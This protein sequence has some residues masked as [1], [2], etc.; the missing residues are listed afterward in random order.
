MINLPIVFSDLEYISGYSCVYSLSK[1]EVPYVTNIFKEDNEIDL[2]F[3]FIG[4]M[5]GT[6]AKASLGYGLIAANLIMN[7][8]NHSTIYQKT[9]L[10][11]GQQRLF[12][13]IKSK[14]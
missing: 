1:S 7:K 10:A 11:L 14:S 12:D 13:D 8:E 9:K 5:S 2:D 3:V 4:G 6:G